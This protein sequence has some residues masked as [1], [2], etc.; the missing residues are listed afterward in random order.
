PLA[1]EL[2]LQRLDGDAV[3]LDRAVATAFADEI[4]DEDALLRVGEGAALAPAAL[5]GGAGLVIDED[6]DAFHL[7][8]LA[9]DAIQLVAVLHRRAGRP[10][11]PDGVLVRLIAHDDDPLH[12][13]VE[14]LLG[15]LPRRE[16]A[17]HRLSAGHGD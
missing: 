17:F 14:D 13:L 8:Q 9:L 7:A 1:A 4:V 2:G 16:L 12:A 3:R 6:R 5:L 10:F 15:D 11:G